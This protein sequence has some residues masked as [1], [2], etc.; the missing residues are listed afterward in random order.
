V[1]GS[2]SGCGGAERSGGEEARARCGGVRLGEGN[3]VGG[4][5]STVNYIPMKHGIF[6]Y[7]SLLARVN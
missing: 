4:R 5:V 1:R 6:N 3:T 7:L 2:V